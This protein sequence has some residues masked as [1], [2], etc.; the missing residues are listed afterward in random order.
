MKKIIALSAITVV[1]CLFLSGCITINVPGGPA[2]EPGKTD[3][4]VIGTETPET[5]LPKE[6]GE[7]EAP[8][9]EAVE[10][11]PVTVIDALDYE[12]EI[13]LTET[14]KQIGW[15]GNGFKHYIKVPKLTGEKPGAVA[16]NYLMY[17]LVE[18]AYNDLQNNREDS[19]IIMIGYKYA[20][21]GDLFAFR[22]NY[23]VGAQCA[24][25]GTSY[26]SYYYDASSDKILTMTE[27]LEAKGTEEGALLAAAKNSEMYKQLM[28][29]DDI[30]KITSCLISEEGAEL[31]LSGCELADGD[32][33]I[34]V[35][36]E[37][38][39]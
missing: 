11:A 30:V 35:P 33:Q 26:H 34:T 19:L 23:S 9:T 5:E 16:L 28:W 25:I 13:I 38:Y 37:L 21:E 15:D 6:E 32:V 8:E 17:Q 3:E 22:I 12:K 14:S 20:V 31:T 4:S 7:T 24:G 29:Y 36:A 10:E 39:K 27:Y 2:A 1:L 18:D